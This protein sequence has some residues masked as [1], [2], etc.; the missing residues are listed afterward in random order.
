M[1]QYLVPLVPNH[2]VVE[3]TLRDIHDRCSVM[4][5][6]TCNKSKIAV[7]SACVGLGRTVPHTD[8]EGVFI[9]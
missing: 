5:T 1:Y 7:C 4:D 3:A 8:W 6:I 2:V 9:M